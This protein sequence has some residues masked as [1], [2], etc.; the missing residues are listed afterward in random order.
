[1]FEAMSFIR[2]VA[3][4]LKVQKL[5]LR[6]ISYQKRATS[7][8]WFKTPFFFRLQHS[9]SNSAAAVEQA[10]AVPSLTNDRGGL[11]VTADSADVAS[12]KWPV[13]DNSNVPKTLRA[14][15][16]NRWS[17]RTGLVGI[18]LGMTQMWSKEGFPIAVTVLQVCVCVCVCV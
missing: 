2:T 7:E 11:P 15:K 1:M 5:I 13:C 8:L 17:R 14:R 9:A 10:E 4:R 16:W 6:P 12:T 18:K 3:S